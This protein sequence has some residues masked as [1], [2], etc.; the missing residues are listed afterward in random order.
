[1]TDE[2]SRKV[3]EVCRS[4]TDLLDDPRNTSGNFVLSKYPEKAEKLRLVKWMDGMD[5][6]DGWMDGWMDALS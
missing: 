6:M 3:Y 5:G 2:K 4:F 1:M